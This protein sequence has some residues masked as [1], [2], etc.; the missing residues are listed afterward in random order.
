MYDINNPIWK[1]INKELKCQ[2]IYEN[3]TALSFY[4]ISPKSPKHA[5]VAPKGQYINLT[6][7][8]TNATL[9]E[10]LGLNEAIIATIKQLDF[11]DGYK[12]VINNGRFAH[13]EIFHLHYHLRGD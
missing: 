8:L 12:V 9:N 5:L 10:Q 4:D 1:I 7:F 11:K 6:D 2:L 3:E 13:Q